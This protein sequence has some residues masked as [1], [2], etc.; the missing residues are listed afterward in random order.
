MTNCRLHASIS[1][2]VIHYLYGS[3][4]YRI[5]LH[6]PFFLLFRYL[7]F[8]CIFF[9]FTIQTFHSLVYLI[10]VDCSTHSN[11]TVEDNRRSTSRL[12][13]VYIMFERVKFVTKYSPHRIPYV[14]QMIHSMAKC[15]HAYIHQLV[16]L[17]NLFY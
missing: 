10:D 6:L 5:Q 15:L 13:I 17:Y 11:C 1:R 14:S 8:V 4:S 16:S 7:F 3:L 9:H 12:P 2:Y